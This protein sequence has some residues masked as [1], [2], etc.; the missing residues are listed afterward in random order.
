MSGL[1]ELIIFLSIN[2]A[3]R[4]DHTLVFIRREWNCNP[5]IHFTTSLPTLSTQPTNIIFHD[6]DSRI[7]KNTDSCLDSNWTVF[8]QHNIFFTSKQF[9]QYLNLRCFYAGQSLGSFGLNPN[10]IN[11]NWKL[12]FIFRLWHSSEK[13]IFVASKSSDFV[14]FLSME[15]VKVVATYRKF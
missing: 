15:N 14:T 13:K 12:N 5:G 1:I 2:D 8:W 7:T 6:F 9:C 10:R 3:H 4:R 11:C